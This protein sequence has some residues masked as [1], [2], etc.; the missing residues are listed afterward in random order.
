M[1]IVDGELWVRSRI[2]MLGYY[3]DDPVDPDG[4]RPTGDLVEIVDGRVVFR[5]RR[6]EII[7]VGGTKVHPLPIEERIGAVPGVGWPAS[8]AGPTR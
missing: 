2:G 7:N 5:G 6:S 3:G 4:W 1:K 8:T